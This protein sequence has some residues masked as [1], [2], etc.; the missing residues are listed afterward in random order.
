[1]QACIYILIQKS[2]EISVEKSIEMI[3]THANMSVR[4][5]TQCL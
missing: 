4:I 3:Q 5:L 1:M 2:A